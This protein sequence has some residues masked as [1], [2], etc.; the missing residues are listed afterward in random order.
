MSAG[1]G[2]GAGARLMCH[3]EPGVHMAATIAA[4]RR[5]SK[6][7]ATL[8]TVGYLAGASVMM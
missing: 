8:L 4:E 2:E 1:R 7:E 5:T 3:M 6:R